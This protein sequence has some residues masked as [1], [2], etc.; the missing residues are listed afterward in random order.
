MRSFRVLHRGLNRYSLA[1]VLAV[2]FVL[3]TMLTVQQQRVIE[4]QQNLIHV[5]AGDSFAY[6]HVIAQRVRDNPHKKQQPA[7]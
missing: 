3:M 7:K 4:A 2:A 5:L 1:A 6:W